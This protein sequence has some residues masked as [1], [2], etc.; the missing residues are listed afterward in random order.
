MRVLTNQ[1]VLYSDIE[2]CLTLPFAKKFGIATSVKEIHKLLRDARHCQVVRENEDTNTGIVPPSI[3]YFEL[4]SIILLLKKK[5]KPSVKKP[6]VRNLDKYCFFDKYLFAGM[7]INK[8]ADFFDD[9]IY[10][11]G[12]DRV[13]QTLVRYPDQIL[14]HIL[15]GAAFYYL[16]SSTS[17]T[18]K[19]SGELDEN[20]FSDLLVISHKKR[21]EK[22]YFGVWK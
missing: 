17:E 8:P 13:S 6:Y 1:D 11:K 3:P 12:N 20:F 2:S 5:I 10:V 16:G 19:F 4:K 9:V 14:Q 22:H 21:D 15:K 7:I 18:N